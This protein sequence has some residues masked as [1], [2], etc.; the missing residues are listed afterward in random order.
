MLTLDP[1]VI[2]P[3]KFTNILDAFPLYGEPIA[4]LHMCQP[5]VRLLINTAKTGKVLRP[6]TPTRIR[7][8]CEVIDTHLLD[9]FPCW[10]IRRQIGG[11]KS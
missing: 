7:L 6:L 8:M 10:D 1:P 9:D 3:I 5:G 2:Q 11:N 4:V